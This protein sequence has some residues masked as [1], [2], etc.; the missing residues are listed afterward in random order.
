MGVKK[1]E[2]LNCGGETVA[3]ISL[4][5]EKCLG[6]LKKQLQQNL[7]RCQAIV[8]LLDGI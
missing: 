8:E 4:E 7:N 6:D 5:S 2:I 1:F 3:K